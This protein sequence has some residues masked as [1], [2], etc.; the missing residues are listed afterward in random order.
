MMD[1]AELA[2][3]DPRVRAILTEPDSY[4]SEALRRAWPQAGADIQAILDRRAQVRRHRS[5]GPRLLRALHRRQPVSQSPQR[6]HHQ[7]GRAA[8]GI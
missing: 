8:P 6:P 5:R 2:A 3:A 4:F 7:A 1:G